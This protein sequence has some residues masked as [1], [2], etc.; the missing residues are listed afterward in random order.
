MLIAHGPIGIDAP[1]IEPE[2]RTVSGYKKQL[3]DTTNGWWLEVTS[4]D[5]PN[6][7]QI[8][9]NKTTHTHNIYIYNNYPQRSAIIWMI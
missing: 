6:Y 2:N 1:F 4:T 7:P 5:Q 8:K 3:L 9:S